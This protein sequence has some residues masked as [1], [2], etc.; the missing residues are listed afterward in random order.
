ML[1]AVL[2]DAVR[3]FIKYITFTTTEKIFLDNFP[4][5]ACGSFSEHFL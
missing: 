4:C 3:M 5:L 1:C 2:K